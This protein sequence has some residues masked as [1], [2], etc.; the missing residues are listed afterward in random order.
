MKFV[1]GVYLG[2]SEWSSEWRSE[3]SSEWISEWRSEWSSE[4]RS[5]WSSEWSSEW[6]SCPV[7]HSSAG[8]KM[9][10]KINI[11]NKKYFLPSK[12]FK[13]LRLY[14]YNTKFNLKN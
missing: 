9:G 4:W 1:A 2:S 14:M 12:I 13:F 6:S 11:R 10:G 8:G 3:W 7:K 5:K